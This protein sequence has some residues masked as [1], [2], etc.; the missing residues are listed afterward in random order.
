MTDT[1]TLCDGVFVCALT[2]AC[3]CV[4]VE[5][6]GGCG[7]EGLPDLVSVLR[8]IATENISNLPPGGGLA[9]K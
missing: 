5:L 7:E 4:S 8:N 9:S 6:L 1:R 3:V 2:R